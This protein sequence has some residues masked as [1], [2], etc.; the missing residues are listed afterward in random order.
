MTQTLNQIINDLDLKQLFIHQLNRVNCTKSYLI[1][2]LPLLKE[3]ASFHN[4][5]LA[6]QETLD[7]IKRQQLR[8]DEMYDLLGTR[9]SDEGCEVVKSIIEE[10]SN[11]G[12]TIGK[13]TIVNDMDIILYTQLIENIEL[14]SFRMLKLIA[15]FMGNN[16]ITQMVT[17]CFDENID[18]DRLFT[19]I[20]EEYMAQKTNDIQ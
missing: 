17:E 12:S 16:Q 19:L 6:I 13:S 5:K 15:G 3:I 1:R 8:I 2:N 18:N 4:M 9:A 20:S 10:A 11:L 7:D 14:T